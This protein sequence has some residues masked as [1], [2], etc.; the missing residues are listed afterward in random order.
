MYY[1]LHQTNNIDATHRPRQ[2]PGGQTPHQ[3]TGETQMTSYDATKAAKDPLTARSCLVIANSC[4][5]SYFKGQ[6]A[7]NQPQQQIQ[8]L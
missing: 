2:P 4:Q 8:R 1:L 6:G 7:F 5:D 3:L